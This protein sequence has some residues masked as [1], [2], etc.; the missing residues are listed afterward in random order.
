LSWTDKPACLEVLSWCRITDKVV[1]QFGAAYEITPALESAVKYTVAH[2]TWLYALDTKGRTRIRFP[3]EA[4]V[5]EIVSG[6]RA[7]PGEVT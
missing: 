5:E 2:S 4:T 1:S 7:L 3:Y 6:I